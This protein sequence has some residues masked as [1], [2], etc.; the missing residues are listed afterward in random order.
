M[1]Q[2]I[3]TGA[4]AIL[5]ALPVSPST[6]TTIS[7]DEIFSTLDF[8]QEFVGHARRG[9][10]RKWGGRE[11]FAGTAL[12]GAISKAN[13]VWSS[14]V[15]TPFSF[16]YV[17]GSGIT[18]TVG[19]T[20]S[21]FYSWTDSLDPSSTLAIRA[22]AAKD[23]FGIDLTSLYLS[24]Y[25][26]LPDLSGDRDGDYL[27]VSDAMLHDGF[28]LMGN[29]VMTFPHPRRGR[30]NSLSYRILIGNAVA[31]GG[32]EPLSAVPEPTTAIMMGVGCTLLVASLVF[33]RWRTVPRK[34]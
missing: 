26:S 17:P 3:R 32:E 1:S 14:G 2:S 18:M 23:R 22:Y 6:I 34:N 10:L 28:T 8:E 11:V 24:G 19:G 7:S 15:L 25:G 4:L 16:T 30:P 20:A 12:K 13:Y 9:N 33:R 27:L 5:L 29:S 31:T 21:A